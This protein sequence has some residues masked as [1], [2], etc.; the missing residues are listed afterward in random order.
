[1]ASQSFNACEHVLRQLEVTTNKK[2][3]VIATLRKDM[4]LDHMVRMHKLEIEH[5]E[6]DLNRANK[7][8]S[9]ICAPPM[10]PISKY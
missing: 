10:F 5:L 7:L 3:E 4:F 1:M 2:R 6:A 8:A 9:K